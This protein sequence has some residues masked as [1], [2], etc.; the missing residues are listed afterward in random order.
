MAPR[1]PRAVSTGP[2][3]RAGP[4][5]CVPAPAPAA[6]RGPPGARAV[7][8]KVGGV[9][10]VGAVMT[11]LGVVAP[12]ARIARAQDLLYVFVP[13][14]RFFAFLEGRENYLFLGPHPRSY[15]PVTLGIA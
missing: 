11:M 5:S 15:V 2:A 8:A 3:R 10:K 7:L 4:R 6:P 1:V 13:V 14:G 9:I 12:S